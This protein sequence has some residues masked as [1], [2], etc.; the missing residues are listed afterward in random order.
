MKIKKLTV[1][2]S[3]ALVVAYLPAHGEDEGLGGGPEIK[4]RGF[5]TIGVVRSTNSKSDVM[6]NLSQP[7][8]AGH[9]HKWDF[10]VDSKLAVQ[11]DAKFNDRLSASW[12]VMSQRQADDTYRPHTEMA[13]AKLQAS[14]DISIRL[15][16][17]PA[18]LFM[19]SEY[20]KVG[21]VNPWV[22]QPN[23]VYFQVPYNSMNGGDVSYQ[24]NKGDFTGNF[25]V[26]AGEMTRVGIPSEGYINT[27]RGYHGLSFN[28]IGE[29]G[30]V[31]FRIGHSR[32]KNQYTGESLSSLYDGLKNIANHGNGSCAT[33]TTGAGYVATYGSGSCPGISQTIYQRAYNAAYESILA[34]PQ[35]QQGLAN[36]HAG[37]P[38]LEYGSVVDYV[39][40]GT[41]DVSTTAGANLALLQ[42]NINNAIK[43]QATPG[44]IAVTQMYNGAVQAGGGV[45]LNS[46]SLKSRA[47]E[48]YDEYN[49]DKETGTFTGVGVIVD[50]GD[51]LLQSEYTVRK[52]ESF[53]ADTTGW[54]VTAGRRFG[55][56]MPY[57]S[58]SELKVDSPKTAPYLLTAQEQA[59][60]KSL[61][62]PAALAATRGLAA[63]PYGLLNSISTGVDK[64][65]Q[66][67]SY[68][69]K[70]V[71]LGVRWDFL[72]SAAIK[73]QW[74]R[75]DTEKYARGTMQN[76]VH[77]IAGAT[78]LITG[79][80][81]P[82]N[83]STVLSA[84]GT[85]VPVPTD[86]NGTTVLKT[87]FDRTKPVNV[88]SLA[89]DFV[90]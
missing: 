34:N 14:P 39:I 78:D 65:V 21:Y 45:V 32:T 56:V 25:Q 73:F 29:Y 70:N 3:A 41:H 54:Y 51:W 59:A 6:D 53:L 26:A 90:F 58:L 38:N 42:T 18:P 85:D 61:A 40:N 63:L 87:E 15:G 1:A 47:G 8:G 5:G 79:S 48:L 83:G 52:V 72:K 9:S 20:R 16:R 60:L 86:P 23:E 75:I 44:A 30:P 43:T 69:Q 62:S 17:L 82:T 89:V 77:T 37:L 35:I 68:G 2:V 19:V 7:R 28:F 84:L 24:F 88:F 22:R 74:D 11:A 36:V 57:I 27:L 76:Y 33:P 66:G 80:P 12:Q 10:G 4:L 64:T 81:S 67:T 71:S 50:T 46:D 13:F 55:K 31:T 49:S